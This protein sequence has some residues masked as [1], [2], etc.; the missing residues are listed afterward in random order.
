MQKIKFPSTWFRHLQPDLSIPTPLGFITVYCHKVMSQFKDD[1]GEVKLRKEGVVVK[2]KILSKSFFI[3]ISQ[4]IYIET[5]N[6]MGHHGGRDKKIKVLMLLNS[7][8][9]RE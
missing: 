8:P 3:V 2:I 6:L 1:E 4:L 5:L 7:T 9:F